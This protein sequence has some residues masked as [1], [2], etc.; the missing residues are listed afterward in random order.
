MPLTT[1]QNLMQLLLKTTNSIIKSSGKIPSLMVVKYI[2]NQI[3]IA[4]GY[5]VCEMHTLS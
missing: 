5:H 4:N 1:I 2:T 3:S